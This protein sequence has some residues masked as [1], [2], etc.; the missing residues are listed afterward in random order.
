MSEDE[1]KEAADLLSKGKTYEEV[2]LILGVHATTISRRV[3]QYKIYGSSLFS[4]DPSPVISIA[5]AD[6]ESFSNQSSPFSSWLS[7][8]KTS[9]KSS[10]ES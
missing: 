8:Q 7:Q 2:A 10:S 3:R 4:K 9:R 6:T 1:V 5:Y